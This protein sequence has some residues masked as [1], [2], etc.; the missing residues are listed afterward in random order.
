VIVKRC[1]WHSRYVGYRIV[2]GIASWRGARLVVT[3]GMCRG[4]ARRWRAESGGDLVG[5]ASAPVIPG[6]MP[7]AGLAVAVL[8]AIVLAARPIDPPGRVVTGAE[9]E[10]PASDA[11]L[12]SAPA[13]VTAATTGSAG[14]VLPDMHDGVAAVSG[15]SG[16]GLFDRRIADGTRGLP[17]LHD[18]RHRGG[19]LA[20]RRAPAA[21]GNRRALAR[22][23][24]TPFRSRRPRG[25][26]VVLLV[27][28]R[29]VGAEERS[30]RLAAAPCRQVPAR[31]AMRTVTR[32]SPASTPLA[33][34]P[35]GASPPSAASPV[36]TV[37]VQAP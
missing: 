13:T 7:K 5:S 14:R 30:T 15:S 17:A 31:A 35:C 23:A 36:R 1:A 6:W 8:A 2:Y 19:D 16:A 26:A 34:T 27:H 21:S 9:S 32:R 12:P 18:A 3:D 24:S 10:S 20:I 22:S 11:A 25:T 29:L 37:T 4:C 33:P 28:A